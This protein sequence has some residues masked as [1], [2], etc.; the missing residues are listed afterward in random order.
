MSENAHAIV[1]LQRKTTDKSV[2]NKKKQRGVIL[3]CTTEKNVVPL[4]SADKVRC[5]TQHKADISATQYQSR[6]KTNQRTR[7][8]T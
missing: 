7:H 2:S 8:L 5:Y 4:Q 1:S 3:I 6:N